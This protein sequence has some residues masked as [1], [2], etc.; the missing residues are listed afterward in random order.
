M[1]CVLHQAFLVQHLKPYKFELNLHLKRKYF[2][3]DYSYCRKLEHYYQIIF[4]KL[5]KK[6]TIHFLIIFTNID[7]FTEVKK[8][9]QLYCH[10]LF[11]Y[12]FMCN[13]LAYHYYISSKPNFLDF[14]FD[15]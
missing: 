7:T 4:C 3:L 15:P 13:S 10:V 6:F 5:W 11:F 2:L 12:L 14:L 9:L 8:D 1:Q